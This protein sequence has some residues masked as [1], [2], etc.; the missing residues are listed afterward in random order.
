M[1]NSKACLARQ[2]EIKPRGLTALGGPHDLDSCY[3]SFPALPTL[4]SHA[5]S[6]MFQEH[7]RHIPTSGLCIGCFHRQYLS[8]PA[9]PHDSFSHFIQVSAHTSP[10]WREIPD[11]PSHCPLQ[12]NHQHLTVTSSLPWFINYYYYYYC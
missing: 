5:A 10:P 4:H 9:Y 1:N 12:R 8:C 2:P 7:T 6:L 3:C 11:P